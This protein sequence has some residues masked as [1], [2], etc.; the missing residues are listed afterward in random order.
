MLQLKF[1]K[2]GL[3]KCLMDGWV[4]RDAPIVVPELT[5]GQGDNGLPCCMPRL[6]VQPVVAD[7]CG[8]II[9]LYIG[10]N[11]YYYISME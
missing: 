10:I 8:H 2:H 9:F 5:L 1:K 3:F 11:I 7:S 6:L 4:M